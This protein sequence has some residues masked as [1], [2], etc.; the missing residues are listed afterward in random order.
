MKSLS[1]Y[2][3]RYLKGEL[4][5][6]PM[7]FAFNTPAYQKGLSM[8]IHD[9]YPAVLA[10]MDR[11]YRKYLRT[12]DVDRRMLVGGLVDAILA[13]RPLKERSILAKNGS[14]KPIWRTSINLSSSHSWSRS[15]TTFC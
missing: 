7:Y 2:F 6:S 4:P 14:T 8:R 10:E 3:S 11:F 13:I 12:S 5:S 1:S 9:E 15:G